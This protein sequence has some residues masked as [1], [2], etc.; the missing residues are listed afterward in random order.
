MRVLTLNAGSSSLKAR[1]DR[2]TGPPPS[3][4]PQPEWTA[5]LE[6]TDSLERAPR[7]AEYGDTLTKFL[8]SIPGAVDAVGHRI[9]HGGPIH[10]TSF[11]TSAVVETIALASAFAPE[12]NRRALQVFDEARRFFGESIP[13]VAVFD[14][15]FH[16][17]LAPAAY[18]YPGPYAWLEEGIRRYGFHG[19][20]HRYASRTAAKILGSESSSLKLVTC[21]LGNGASLAAVRGGISIDTTMGFTPLEGL[22]MGSR[23]G[24][25]DPGILVHLMRRHGYTA[26][27]LD[28]L[29]NKE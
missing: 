19:I 11:L 17:T 16:A 27:E 25:L 3:D 5:S 28:H 26:D 21:H 18:V 6:R 14:T 2:I 4:S 29:L 1:C 24:S 13:Q 23:S 15:A 7:E 8:A 22:M 10:E 9:V 20:S 12:H